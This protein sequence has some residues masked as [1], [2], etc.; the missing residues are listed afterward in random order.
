MRRMKKPET[1]PAPTEETETT[2]ALATPADSGG[3]LSK[4]SMASADLV[5]AVAEPSA[6]GAVWFNFHS[7]KANAAAT[8]N[9][10]LGNPPEGAPYFVHGGTYCAMQGLV[11][12]VLDTHEFWCR[13]DG[14]GKP[15]E[16]SD[17]KPSDRGWSHHIQA[18]ILILPGE[19][20]LP[21]GCPSVIATYA[22]FKTVKTDAVSAHLAAIRKACTAEWAKT[23]G[24]IAASVPTPLRMVSTLRMAP[25]Q[26]SKAG[27]TYVV[28]KS[29]AA[30]I[31]TKQIEAAMAWAEAGSP[32]LED[33]ESVFTQRVDEIKAL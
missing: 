16:T 6:G 12:A 20:D 28:A 4:Y 2:T 11:F 25:P 17:S 1:T 19:S 22:E 14:Q 7:G 26:K 31:S 33:A 23:N 29:K 8:V 9:E 15:T 3:F 27:Y 18:L 24:Q 5:P 10:K 13:K 32:G 30:V 21:S